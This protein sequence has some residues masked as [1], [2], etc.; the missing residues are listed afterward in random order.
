MAQR[1]V[2]KDLPSDADLAAVSRLV[3][4]YH[5][6]PKDKDAGIRVEV[7]RRMGAVPTLI[8][9]D[10]TRIGAVQPILKKIADLARSVQQSAP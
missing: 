4:N 7:Y 1:S 6:G 3:G 2:R 10:P 9:N 5:C 8:C